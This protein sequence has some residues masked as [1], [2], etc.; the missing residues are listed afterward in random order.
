MDLEWGSLICHWVHPLKVAILEAALW[1]DHPFKPADMA[2]MVPA[3]D[4]P[5]NSVFHHCKDLQERNLIDI[6][7]METRGDFDWGVLV[8]HFLHP[9]KVGI[10]ETL[11]W[12]GLPMSA[13]ELT[14]SF[15]NQE[16][17]GN[18]SYHLRDLARRGA[19][20]I[21]SARQVRGARETYY[22]LRIP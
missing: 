12:V 21:F 2:K 7:Q 10:L 19:V 5:G 3:G 6:A 16:K 18:M 4:Y 17:L 11:R 1:I 15:E 9:T 13:N 20:E 22:R 8:P 14:C